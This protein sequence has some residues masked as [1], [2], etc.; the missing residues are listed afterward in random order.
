MAAVLVPPPMRRG[1]GEAVSSGPAGPTIAEV[2]EA[3]TARAFEAARRAAHGVIAAEPEP[4]G[5]AVAEG[6]RDHGPAAAGRVLPGVTA[7]TSG[8]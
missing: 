4:A 7:V 1:Y 6:I 3:G 2:Q 8:R 5:Q